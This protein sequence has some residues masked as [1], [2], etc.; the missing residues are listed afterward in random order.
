MNRILVLAPLLLLP[1]ACVTADSSAREALAA[2][3]SGRES[4][5]QNELPEAVDYFTSALRSNPD[6]AEAYFERG[7]VNIRLRL[8]KDVEGDQRFAPYWRLYWKPP[9]AP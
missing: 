6:L 9:R 7:A 5:R 8:K 2:L 1:A 4:A 3:E